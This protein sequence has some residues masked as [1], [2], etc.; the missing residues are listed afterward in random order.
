M[1]EQ[2]LEQDDENQTAWLNLQRSPG[3]SWWCWHGSEFETQAMYLK[4][5]MRVNPKSETAPRLVKWLL[6]NR[7]H[8][9]Y[10]NST[11]DTALCVEAFAE[12]L[13]ATGEDRPNMTVEILVDGT[14]RK[15]V[16]ITP[17]N[18]LTIDNT[19]VL[20][21]LDV[22][23]GEHVIEIRKKEL[24]SRE[25]GAGSRG[26]GAEISSLA[27]SPS[28][29]APHSPV[30][31]NAYLENFTLEEQITAAGLEVKIDRRYWLLTPADKT[32]NVA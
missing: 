3:W 4:L 31:F 11:R 23:S 17:E 2:Y 25:Q 9:T 20:E 14:V 19:F 22:T 13:R 28:S 15:S 7:K 1:L 27:P 12:F 8:A 29:L 26:Q 21:G 6:N 5:L 24:G 16:D 32:A 30:Y 18:M 10:W